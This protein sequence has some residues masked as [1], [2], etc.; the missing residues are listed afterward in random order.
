VLWYALG[1]LIGFLLLYPL[2]LLVARVTRGRRN[3]WLR[4]RGLGFLT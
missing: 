1:L 4:R 3:R 2:L